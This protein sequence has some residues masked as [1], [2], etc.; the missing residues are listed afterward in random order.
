MVVKSGYSTLKGKMYEILDVSSHAV[1]PSAGKF[2]RAVA[3]TDVYQAGLP[4]AELVRVTDAAYAVWLEQP[5][6][7]AEIVTRFLQ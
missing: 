6:H 5:Q 3:V 7:T 1:A 2:Y 4:E